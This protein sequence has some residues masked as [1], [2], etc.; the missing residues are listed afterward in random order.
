MCHDGIRREI[1]EMTQMLRWMMLSFLAGTL[2]P[3]CASPVERETPPSG[4][5]EEAAGD[6]SEREVT[7]NSTSISQ[8]F[9]T[10]DEY[11]AF[12]ESRAAIDGHWYREIRPGVYRLET[13]N[14]RG[15]EVEKRIFTREELERQF[16]FSRQ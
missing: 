8:R 4:S 15:P 12:L 6:Q 7:G 14:Y 16:G 5:P 3:A 11:L 2:T 10:L 1:V 9:Q 13:G